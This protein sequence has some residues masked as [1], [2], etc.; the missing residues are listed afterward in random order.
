MILQERDGEL[1]FFRQTDHALLSGA[2]ASAWGNDVV[3]FPPRPEAT[4]VAAARH[5]DGWSEWEL[6]P[7][8]R[9]DGEPVDFIRVPVSDHVPLY[10]RGIDLVEMEGPFAGLVA[11]LHGERLYTRPFHPGMDP[12]LEHLEG[13]DLRL[14]QTYVEGERSRQQ[15]L[16]GLLDPDAGA[17]A[18]E[19]WRL[20]QVWDRLSLMVCMA[21]VRPGAKQ[22]FRPFGGPDEPL[23]ITAESPE[24]GVLAIDPYPFK[25]PNIEFDV[26]YVRTAAQKWKDDVSFRRDFRDAPHEVLRFSCIRG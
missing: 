13:P 6:A 19:A 8:L 22:T 20:L 5:D 9:P 17:D 21:P 12:R 3:P 23:A 1:F 4:I 26:S 18:D 24:A 25:E 15:R 14:A 11:S 7:K 10:K 16:L 2:F